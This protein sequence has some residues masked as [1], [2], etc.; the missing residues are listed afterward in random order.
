MKKGMFVLILLV[1]SYLILNAREITATG[2]RIGYNN[3][4]FIGN[5]TPGK[6]VKSIPGFTIG[7]FACYEFNEKLLFQPEVLLTTKGSMINTIGDIEQANIFVYLEMPLLVKMRFFKDK[8]LKP[9]IFGGPAFNLKTLAIN[10]VGVLGAI[11]DFDSG[12]IIGA[13]LDYRRISFEIRFEKGMINF[14][15]STDDID[16]KNQTIS[17]LFGISFLSKGGK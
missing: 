11:N 6:N 16:L 1:S 13:G 8:K 17:F 4:T 5:D 12:L 3:S 9:D 7:G 14:D 15:N 10:D 2:L